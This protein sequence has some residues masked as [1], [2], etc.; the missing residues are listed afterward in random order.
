M[1]QL[2]LAQNIINEASTLFVVS[3]Y[4]DLLA[5]V[6]SVIY[7]LETNYKTFAGSDKKDLVIQIM[8]SLSKL[9]TAEEQ[10]LFN[11][12]LPSIPTLIDDI[13]TL[14]KSKKLFKKH[15]CFC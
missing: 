3:N 7:F 8:T 15:K 4:K 5:K 10:Q 13:V 9:L 2:I 1:A 11:S 12:V 14:A 6:P